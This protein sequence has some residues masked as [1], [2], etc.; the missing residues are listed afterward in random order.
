[1]KKYYSIRDA[2]E[3]LLSKGYNGYVVK[4]GVLNDIELYVHNDTIK[5]MKELTENKKYIFLITPYYLNHNQNYFTIR[6]Y[7]KLPKKYAKLVLSSF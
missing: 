6:K 7:T 1:M 5:A 3:D 2:V 4:E